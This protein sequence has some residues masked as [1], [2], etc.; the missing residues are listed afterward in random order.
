MAQSRFGVLGLF[1]LAVVACGGS[2]DAPAPPATPAPAP[3][4]VPAPA[5][6]A[7][8]AM[9]PTPESCANAQPPAAR[10]PTEASRVLDGLDSG[11]TPEQLRAALARVDA[12]IA[13]SP[14]D[15]SAHYVRGVLLGALDEPA[16][17]RFAAYE[18]AFTLDTTDA[19]AAYNAGAVRGAVGDDEGAAQWF[20]RA[21]LVAPGHTD[22]QYNLGQASYNL[23]R[24]ARA[25]DAFLCARAQ[26]PEPFDETKKVAQALHA[27][28]RFE[29]ALAARHEMWRIRRESAHPRFA[30]MSEAVIDQL[31]VEGH[32][33]M[34]SET[35][36]PDAEPDLRYLYVARAYVEEGS[37]PVQQ[38]Q[39][40]TSAVAREL[41]TAALIGYQ[42]GTTHSTTSIAFTQ[43]PTYAEVRPTLVDVIGRLLR[44]ESVPAAAS[45]SPR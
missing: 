28:G 15:A 42:Q 10:P 38:V 6:T 14:S 19:E 30:R 20:E 32:L 3:A 9:P 4:P 40:E 29:E 37:P 11:S 1:G 8:A 13:A 36:P 17:A 18:R 35:A 21:V 26:T 45:S 16:A 41:G 44:G 39:L 7:G 2:D 12:L 31:R 22:A 23:G 34:I 43:L 25:L 24:H 5:P 33:V 27:L